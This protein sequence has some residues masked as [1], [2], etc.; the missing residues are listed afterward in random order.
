M[1]KGTNVNDIRVHE[2]NSRHWWR[3]NIEAG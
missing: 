1:A 2:Y 3:S